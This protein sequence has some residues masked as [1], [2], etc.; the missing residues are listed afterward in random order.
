MND[1]FK[2]ATLATLILAVC[3]FV[4]AEEVALKLDPNQTAIQWSL[5][6]NVHTVH[7]TFQLKR[8]DLRFDTA[9]GKAQ[10]E[11]VVDM[12]SAQSGN[13]SRDKNMH[14]DVLQTSKFAEA[15]FV[16]S[17]VEG[18]WAAQ[19]PSKLTFTGTLK[20]HGG[21][22][23]MKLEAQVLKSGNGYTADTRFVVPY[24]EWGMKNPSFFAFRVEDKVTVE[25][26]T[27]GTAAH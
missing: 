25:I 22:H 26:K 3:S 19:G 7:G 13:S 24:V 6:G 1:M 21:D 9:T 10:G 14:K 11:L 18:D 8:G 12:L 2:T 17:R 16:P 27:A 4:N 5:V 23:P 15:T 20:L